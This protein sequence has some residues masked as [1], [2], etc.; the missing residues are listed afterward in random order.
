VLHAGVDLLV[1]SSAGT[2]ESTT[3]SQSVRL[4]VA[5]GRKDV[6]WLPTVPRQIQVLLYEADHVPRT[7][8]G[9]AED[10]QVRSEHFADAGEGREAH[11]MMYHILTHYNDLPEWTVFSKPMIQSQDLLRQLSSFSHGGHRSP[12][13]VC[14]GCASATC[15][16]GRVQV[17]VKSQDAQTPEDPAAT[18]VSVQEA[19]LTAW[20]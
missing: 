18:G 4:V 1:T 6:P 17:V 16:P 12:D 20:L 15:D 7:L 14:L 3:A 2:L 8:R 10:A 19:P 5:G 11:M 13:S 9:Q